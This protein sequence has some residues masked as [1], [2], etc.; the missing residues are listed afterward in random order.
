FPGKGAVTV[1]L[2]VTDDDAQTATTT[3]SV[4][5]RAAGSAAYP[6]AVIDTPGVL[7]YW[8]RGEGSGTSLADSVGS[9]T[10]TAAGGALLGVPGAVAG[11]SN[12]GTRFD[13]IND[14]GSARVDLSG[15]MKLT[16]EF[17][18]KWNAFANDDD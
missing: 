13:G 5:V 2:R 14:A 18:L 1:R 11:D 3:H 8:R 17:W 6:D 10:A 15:R 7:D 9:S 12:T 16:V 4:S